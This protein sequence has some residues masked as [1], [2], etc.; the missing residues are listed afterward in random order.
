MKVLLIGRLYTEGFATLIAQELRLLGHEVVEFDPGPKLSDFGSRTAFYSNRIKSIGHG[1]IQSVARGLGHSGQVAK[2]RRVVERA[3]AVDLSL[4]CH[5]FLTPDEAVEVKR[6]TKGPL[7]LWFP[8]AISNFQK[9]MFLNGPYD[10]LFFKDPYIVD[11]LRR[12]LGA[13]VYYLPECYSPRALPPAAEGENLEKCF[14]AD[15]STAGNSYAYRIAFFRNLAQY[16]VKL[17]GLPPPLW[18]RL[19]PV[20]PMV[21]NRFVAGADKAMAFRAA[22]IVVN[23]LHPAEIWGTSTLR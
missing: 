20:A 9:H 1:V 15:I 13:P 18:M 6:L 12:N 3:G 4:I 11:I 10:A 23:N 5:D 17:W 21:Q 22:R 19:G 14:Q 8:D 16:Q 2:L 7:V